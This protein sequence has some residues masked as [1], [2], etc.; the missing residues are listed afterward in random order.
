M[1]ALYQPLRI[2]VGYAQVVSQIGPVLHF[3]FPDMI[4]A[5]FDFLHPLA[6]NLQEL[7]QLDC[8]LDYGFYTMWLL[9]V[10]VLPLAMFGLVALRF[11]WDKRCGTLGTVSATSNL[12]VNC[13]FV[14]FL[15]Y[16]SICNQVF[17]MFNCRMLDSGMQ[18]LFT[19]YSVSCDTV[20][21][22]GFKTIA[23]I[24]VVVFSLGTPVTLGVL[25]IM[26]VNE[27]SLRGASESDRFVTRRV[28]DEL[29]IAD[30]EAADAIRD[31]QTGREYSF[32]VNVSDSHICPSKLHRTP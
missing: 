7:L 5:I 14:V 18:V 20:V 30:N 9:R 10:L 15:I 32:L 16:P 24:I 21:H 1:R 2:L 28:A 22:S 29:K 23:A 31:V 11:G 6:V 4:Q 17:S 19:D 26:R 25:M 8:V 12:K 3:A 13:F 27:Y